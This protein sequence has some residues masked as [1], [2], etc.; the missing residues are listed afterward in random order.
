MQYTEKYFVQRRHANLWLDLSEHEDDAQ[1]QT[2]LDYQYDIALRE[3]KSCSLRVVRKSEVT[4]YTRT[5]A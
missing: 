1:A 5:K 4:L 3:G 2:E